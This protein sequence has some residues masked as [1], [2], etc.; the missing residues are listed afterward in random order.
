MEDPNP[1]ILH[2]LRPPT[3]DLE[4]AAGHLYT[5]LGRDLHKF[6]SAASSSTSLSAGRPVGA[7]RVSGKASRSAKNDAK[8]EALK[9]D[10]HYAYIVENKTL[11]ATMNEISTKHGF[12]AS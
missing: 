7:S 2:P 4:A 11:A 3:P 9:D 6:R 5:I 12:T 1:P 10:I 8:W